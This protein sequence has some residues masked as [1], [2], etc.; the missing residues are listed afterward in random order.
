M[1]PCTYKG[2]DKRKYVY[3]LEGISPRTL[4]GSRVSLKSVVD[5]LISRLDELSQFIVD[6]GFPLPPMFGEN[7]TALRNSLDTL[8]LRHIKFALEEI[9]KKQSEWKYSKNVSHGTHSGANQTL[10]ADDLDLSTL[11]QNMD[12][13]MEPFTMLGNEMSI[14]AHPE[15]SDYLLASSKELT[16]LQQG[17][18]A[19]TS[20]VDQ[21]ETDQASCEME[22][23]NEKPQPEAVFTG[24]PESNNNLT[25]DASGTDG[26]EEIVNQLS[27]RMGNLQVGSDGQVRY[28]GPT[29]HFNLLRMPTPDGLTVHRTIRKD[30]RDYLHRMGIDKEVPKGLEDHLI[31][32]FFTWHNPTVDVVHRGMYESAKQQ[33]TENMEET[34]Y[35][36]EALANAM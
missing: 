23:P 26:M 14:Q 6:Q 34:P 1:R 25:N 21:Q 27:D 8:G 16:E 22:Y 11:D 29:S 5:L 4:T 33:W 17:A 13:L 7:D 10:V 36:S 20:K 3:Y 18:L 32:L 31:N 9:D 30:G 15:T 2:V 35:Y 24:K 12:L 28:Y 19:M